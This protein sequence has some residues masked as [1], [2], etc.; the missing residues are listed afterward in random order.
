MTMTTSGFD[1]HEDGCVRAK[2]AVPP[3]RAE[4]RTFTADVKLAAIRECDEA[5][6]GQVGAILRERGVTRTNLRDWR[7]QYHSGGMAALAGKAGQVPVAISRHVGELEAR[8]VR[9]E[10]EL[11]KFKALV[12]ISG[13]VYALLGMISEGADIDRP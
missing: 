1:A 13:N 4:R 8:N 2:P 12:E 6:H 3:E 7:K 5:E 11:A 9:L 10:A